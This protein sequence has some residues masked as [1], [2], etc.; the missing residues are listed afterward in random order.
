MAT[1]NIGNRET[2]REIVARHKAHDQNG[3][4]QWIDE[5]V[6]ST[7]ELDA[8]GNWSAWTEGP[9]QFWHG[10]IICVKKSETEFEPVMT[11]DVLTLDQQ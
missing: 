4:E 3:V 5:V 6:P 9:R 8:N 1:L 2:R 10:K 11:D 7:R